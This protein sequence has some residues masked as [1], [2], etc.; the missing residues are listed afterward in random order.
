M[1][2]SKAAERTAV[3]LVRRA[4]GLLDAANAGSS[5]FACL[6]SDALDASTEVETDG[7]L[8]ADPELMRLESTGIDDT[9]FALVDGRRIAISPSAV[10]HLCCDGTTTTVRFVDGTQVRLEDEFEDIVDKLA[11]PCAGQP[12]ANGFIP[13]DGARHALRNLLTMVSALTSQAMESDEPLLVKGQEVAARVALLSR[14]S[15]LIVQP[16]AHVTDLQTLVELALADGH[17]SRVRIVGAPVAVG[18][19]T[20]AAIALAVHELEVHSLSCGALSGR[21]GYVS[22]RW[23][24]NAVEQPHIWLQWAERDGPQVRPPLDA[25]SERL[26]A[27]ATPRRLGGVGGVDELPS[28]LVWSLHAPLAALQA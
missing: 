28:G 12:P 8:D 24:I 4:L 10:S 26:L 7:A 21:N 17:S 1:M 14:I 27:V 11:L 22:L 23:E 15:D 9:T 3:V 25:W 2:D 16:E 18:P 6:L 13:V 19:S 5:V 20:A